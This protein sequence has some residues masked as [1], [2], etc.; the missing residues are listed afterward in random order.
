VTNEE[1]FKMLVPWLL[2]VTA[3]MFALGPLVQRW[4]KQLAAKRLG[5][6][7]KW[8]RKRRIVTVML[9]GNFQHQ[10]DDPD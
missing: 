7:R 10:M 4:T 9:P 1:T 2:L 3:V 6:E 8:G 5:V